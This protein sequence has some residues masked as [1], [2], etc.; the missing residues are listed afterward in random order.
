[1]PNSETRYEVVSGEITEA[2]M[3]EVVLLRLRVRPYD[4]EAGPPPT[5]EV[6]ELVLDLSLADRL[7]EVLAF[8]AGATS[9][10]PRL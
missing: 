10:P 4:V 6:V 7:A 9:H 8:L 2:L 3:P 1:M 5:A